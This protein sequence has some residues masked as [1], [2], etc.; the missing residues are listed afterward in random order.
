MKNVTPG[1]W[2]VVQAQYNS[3]LF[4]IHTGFVIKTA[5][6]PHTTIADVTLN[7]AVGIPEKFRKGNAMLM[8]KAPEMYDLIISIA[9]DQDLYCNLPED[10]KERITTILSTLNK[11]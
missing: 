6:F 8:S 10:I 5:S 4:G 3:G 11:L 7:N 9:V 1:P 2:T